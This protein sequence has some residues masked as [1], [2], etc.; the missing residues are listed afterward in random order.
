MN[1]GILKKRLEIVL[2]T[3]YFYVEW[4]WN[5]I[6]AFR[7]NRNVE[8]ELWLMEKTGLLGAMRTQM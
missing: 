8:K 4:I 6:Q 1:T 7:M 3:Y 5:D 2:K